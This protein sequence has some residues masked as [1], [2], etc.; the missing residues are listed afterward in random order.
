ML[1][2]K[3]FSNLTHR[4][5]LG[6]HGA[7]RCCWGAACRRWTTARRPARQPLQGWLDCL[8]MGGWLSVGIT[9]WLQSECPAALRRNAQAD[10]E[11]PEHPPRTTGGT[12]DDCALFAAWGLRSRGG[13]WIHGRHRL[14][15]A[16]AILGRVAIRSALERW[17][18]PG[19]RTVTLIR[20]GG[21]SGWRAALMV[22]IGK[23]PAG[24]RCWR[25]DGR[26][27]MKPG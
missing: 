10:R 11:L 12:T 6:W 8:G 15:G 23:M 4:Q 24:A 18:H 19:D 9:G 17:G 26:A 2:A 22:L 7:P 20:C 16:T 27:A 5:S 3:N 13:G 14:G 21:K 1:E 25:V